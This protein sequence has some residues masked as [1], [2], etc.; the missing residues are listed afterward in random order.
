[1]GTFKVN[2]HDPRRAD[3]QVLRA[4]VAMYHGHV[5]RGT[6]RDPLAPRGEPRLDDAGRSCRSTDRCAAGRTPSGPRIVAR[7]RG[8]HHVARAAMPRIAPAWRAV[9]PSQRPAKRMLFQSS[10]PS[11]VARMAYKKLGSSQNSSS[12]SRLRGRTAPSALITCHSRRTR[13]R[14]ASHSSRTRRRGRACLSTIRWLPSSIRTTVLETPPASTL[15]FA[16]GDT[17]R[18]P[19]RNPTAL[20]ALSSCGSGINSR[21]CQKREA[22]GGPVWACPAGSTKGVDGGRS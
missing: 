3:K 7:R 11:G 16:A 1:M 13:V 2:A 15:A 6:L 14:S 21:A 4:P 20:S 17:S 12:G 18:W 10:L 8:S 22:P 5:P 19:A 9:S